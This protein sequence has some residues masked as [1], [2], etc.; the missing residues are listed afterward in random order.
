MLKVKRCDCPQGGPGH[1]SHR[2]LLLTWS[3]DCFL[4]AKWK[5]SGNFK[6][7][8]LPEAKERTSPEAHAWPGDT[9]KPSRFYLFWVFLL[10]S[11]LLQ[12]GTIFAYWLKPSA[13]AKITA[14]TNKGLA[15]C[16]STDHRQVLPSTLL[17]QLC[18]LFFLTHRLPGCFL[19]DAQDI[20]KWVSAYVDT[21]PAWGP[22]KARKQS[23]RLALIELSAS[24]FQG[25]LPN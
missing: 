3:G 20:T 15:L 25:H 9:E 10:L 7:L 19:L 1:H 17:P 22:G 23:C 18:L 24:P 12:T 2:V 4:T 5:F 21:G 13:K 14:N 6:T 8:V 16:S 11:L